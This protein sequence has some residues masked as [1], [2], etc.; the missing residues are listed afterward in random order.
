M[1]LFSLLHFF[2]KQNPQNLS[3]QAGIP[4]SNKQKKTTMIPQN[5]V[6]SFEHPKDYLKIF[7]KVQL[8]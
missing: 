6:R 1:Q 7:D 2:T 4:R 3:D 8:K 5:Q